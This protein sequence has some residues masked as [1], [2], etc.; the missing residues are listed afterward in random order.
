ME[1]GTEV[2]NAI[3]VCAH[4]VHDSTDRGEGSLLGLSLGLLC[5]PLLALLLRH[6]PAVFL[7]AFLSVLYG[8]RAAAI[9]TA[10][11]CGRGVYV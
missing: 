1:A 5:L 8:H 10:F 3:C 4:E 9:N 7:V 11:A 6:A 2:C